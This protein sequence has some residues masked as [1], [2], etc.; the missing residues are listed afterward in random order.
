MTDSWKRIARYEGVGRS[1]CAFNA[2]KSKFDWDIPRKH[3]FSGLQ[4]M[5]PD[6][7]LLVL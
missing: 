7:S 4:V 1:Q 6:D 3:Y 2:V 5:K